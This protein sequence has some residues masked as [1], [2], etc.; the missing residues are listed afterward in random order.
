MLEVL[1]TEVQKYTR[2]SKADL[3]RQSLHCYQG[4]WGC[5]ISL[6]DR[7]VFVS[8]AALGFDGVRVTIGS[9]QWVISEENH[10]T[11]CRLRNVFPFTAPS[12]ILKQPRT[13][14]VGDRLG[15]ATPGH[16]RAFRSVPGFCPVLAQQSVR[17]LTLTG[18]SFDDMLD[19]VTF[20]VFRED[21][22][23]PYGADGDHLKRPE[24][25]DSALH[26]G[27]TMITLDCSDY[28][29]DE[30]QSVSDEEINKLYQGDSK[31][32]AYYLKGKFGAGKETFR[33]SVSGYRRMYLIYHDAIEFASEMY[34]RFF[35]SEN[36]ADLEISID[37]TS[38]PTTPAQHYYIANEL[39]KHGV[40]PAS[41]APRFC[42]EFQKGIDY[43]GD[44]EQFRSELRIHKAIADEFG[45]KISVH[46]G[47]DKFS[48]FESVGELT[49]GKFHLK[50]A[51]T[52]WLEALNVIAIYD[53]DLFRKICRFSLDEAYNKAKMY[54]HITPDLKS[55]SE[56]GDLKDE[57]LPGL[58]NHNAA[59]QVLHICYGH[60]LNAKNADGTLRFKD[61]MYKI[62]RDNATEYADLLEKHIGK[63]L[64]KL[65]T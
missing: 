41:I 59:R 40:C 16:I 10:K 33:Y 17:E 1:R 13:V 48:I 3:V 54:Y 11:A 58:L 36:S 27:C 35:E 52:S 61:R 2:S 55:I 31:E 45:Y 39:R 34:H 30:L 4:S 53:A 29:R 23:V 21:F 42:G 37:E 57:A 25:I 6:D 9:E 26:C 7:D 32:E 20:A 47:S 18:R 51:G 8:E 49:E 60:I 5:I 14:G 56:I 19:A 12:K 50:T 65:A 44:I 46:S 22:Q 63:H 43:I 64:K 28:I 24:E 15:I 38:K 62:W